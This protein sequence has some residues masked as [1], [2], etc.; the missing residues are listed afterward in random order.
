MFSQKTNAQ[1]LKTLSNI[2][3]SV[4]NVMMS[5]KSLN[6]SSS[7][8]HFF[9]SAL[10]VNEFIFGQTIRDT[11]IYKNDSESYKFMLTLLTKKYPLTRSTY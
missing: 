6:N 10:L 11:M 7:F 5:V 2:I 3:I 4:L 8:F 1:T 9:E